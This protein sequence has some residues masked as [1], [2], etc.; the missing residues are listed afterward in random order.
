MNKVFRKILGIP[1]ENRAGKLFNN[2]NFKAFMKYSVWYY[3]KLGINMENNVTYISSDVYFDSADYTAITV[4]SGVTISREVL[5]LV[6]DYSAHIPMI[7]AGWKAPDGKVAHFIKPIKVG[8][9][10][11]IGARVTLLPG[12]E[13]GDNCIIGAGSVV[14]GKIPNN[15]IVIGN[16][17]KIIGNTQEWAKEKIKTRDWQV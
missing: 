2:L 10:S 8:R 12:T 4:Q 9:D 3:R 1:L 13:I 16:P 6:H 15:C 14:K 5:F 11:F 17:A 7:N